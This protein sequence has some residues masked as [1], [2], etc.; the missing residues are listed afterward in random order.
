MAISS[1]PLKA[2]F[3]GDSE[4]FQKAREDLVVDVAPVQIP[5]PNP[6]NEGRSIKGLHGMCL[7]GLMHPEG[8]G[9]K[10]LAVFV[11]LQ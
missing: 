10:K 5:R 8:V 7:K 9:T 3:L 2:R 4:F 6:Q 11:S 1:G